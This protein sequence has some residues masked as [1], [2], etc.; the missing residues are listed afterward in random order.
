MLKLQL[1][2][3]E[4]LTDAG[5]LAE[6][7]TRIDA[8]ALV[9]RVVCLDSGK[10]WLEDAAW[11]DDMQY[12]D[13]CLSKVFGAA[14]QLL[15]I[16]DNQLA[17]YLADMAIALDFRVTVCDPRES[18]FQT[19]VPEQVTCSRAMPDDAVLALCDHPRG[20]VVT[21]AHDPKVDDMALMEALTS[22]AFYVGALGSRGTNDRRRERLAQL[23]V[24][25]TDLA[26]LHAPVGLNIGSRTPAEIAV[27]I[28][29]ELIATR[30]KLRAGLPATPAA[31][32]V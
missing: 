7:I 21:V 1:R 32:A 20:A 29:A 23:G 9:K 24:S 27:A 22:N 18:A 26:R 30:G 15:L 11:A 31:I 4:H 19:R 16:G 5:E 12:G 6:L 17:W 25:A 13:E 10:T 14:W 28:V 3:V 2:G 8:G